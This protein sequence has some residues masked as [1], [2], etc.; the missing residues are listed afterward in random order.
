MGVSFQSIRRKGKSGN[1]YG[2]AYD[3]TRSPQRKW[4]ALQTTEKSVARQRWTALEKDHSLGEY[5]PWEDTPRLGTTLYDDVKNRYLRLYKR[6]NRPSSYNRARGTLGRFGNY[7]PDGIALQA[8]R[9]HH[10]QGYLSQIEGIDGGAPSPHTLAGQHAFLFG[11][12]RWAKREEYIETSPIKDVPR[13]KKPPADRH[14]LRPRQLEAVKTKVREISEATTMER[15]HLI[16]IIDFATST[17]ARRSEIV[18]LNVRDVDFSRGLVRIRRWT[19]PNTGLE[20]VPKHG[21]NRE[22][23]LFPRARHAIEAALEGRETAAYDP[24]FTTPRGYRPDKNRL[25]GLVTWA[26]E[27]AHPELG[28]TLHWLR[29]TFISWLCNDL[30]VATGK[31]MKIAGHSTIQ[32]TEKYLHV[33]LDDVMSVVGANRTPSHREKSVQSWLQCK[34]LPEDEEQGASRPKV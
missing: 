21:R 9:K 20:F 27:K 25:S 26:F 28:A 14:A 2:I 30:G 15:Q 5:D 13:P 4:V 34:P 19:D 24:V 7:L 8:V 29:H 31:V 22:V 16:P 17:G 1:W 11:F 12:F 23:P 33:T 18:H 32:T 10:I 3:R 6:D